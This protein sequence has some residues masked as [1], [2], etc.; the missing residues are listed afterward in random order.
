MLL[1]PRRDSEWAA[2]SLDPVSA[3]A[4]R[5]YAELTDGRPAHPPLRTQLVAEWRAKGRDR[6]RDRRTP[7]R[8]SGTGGTGGTGGTRSRRTRPPAVPSLYPPYPVSRGLLGW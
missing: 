4:G 8:K 3:V 1:G 5:R 6:R 2:R 7:G